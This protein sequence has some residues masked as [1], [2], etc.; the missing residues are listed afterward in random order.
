VII[1]VLIVSWW[2][3]TPAIVNL[4][5]Q[6]IQG[7]YDVAIRKHDDTTDHNTSTVVTTGVS[8]RRSQASSAATIYGLRQRK[9]RSASHP[10]DEPDAD[11]DADISELDN[12]QDH[13]LGVEYIHSSECS[14]DQDYDVAMEAMDQ[15]ISSLEQTD[16]SIDMSGSMPVASE[17]VKHTGES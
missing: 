3:I 12:D 17:N 1:V 15:S 13:D 9:T 11:A 14:Q 8:T 16:D 5:Q 10:D 7:P 2:L 6:I 4:I